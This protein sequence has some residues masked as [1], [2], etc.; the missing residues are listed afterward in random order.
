MKRASRVALPRPSTSTP[1]AIGSSV[2][3]WPTSRC[4]NA[5]RTRYTA[6][7]LVIPFGLSMQRT[8]FN[9]GRL[10][11]GLTDF[12]KEAFD[13][14]AFAQALVEVE[15]KRRRRAHLQSMRDF[16]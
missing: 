12:A 2:P 8:P 14:F 6:S 9:G 16:A 3:V 11:F 15:L 1:V 4:P 5:R 7:W 13:L 10:F